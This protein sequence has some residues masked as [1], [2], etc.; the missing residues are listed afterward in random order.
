MPLLSWSENEVS[1]H[2]CT[3]DALYPPHRNYSSSSW[4]RNTAAPES[5]HYRQNNQT[6]QPEEGLSVGVCNAPGGR[7]EAGWAE[8]CASD[9]HIFPWAALVAPRVHADIQCP[10][11]L[12]IFS[13]Q[14]SPTSGLLGIWGFDT[15]H[16]N[17]CLG[18]LKTTEVGL[19]ISVGTRAYVG[20]CF[21][22]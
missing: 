1:V 8:G 5:G 11:M 18:P 2:V 20:F 6:T 15:K 14:W 16:Q 9:A 4:K 7:L 12:Q 21:F 22:L 17:W 10:G 3:E 19:L 13:V